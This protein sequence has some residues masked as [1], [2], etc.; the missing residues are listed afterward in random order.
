VARGGVWGW[1]V[2][3]PPQAPPLRGPRTSG[4][5]SSLWVCQ[6]IVSGKLE[7]LIDAPSKI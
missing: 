7:M 2:G 5:L 1:Q 3:R 6:A 4:L